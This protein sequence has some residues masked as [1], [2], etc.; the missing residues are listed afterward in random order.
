MHNDNRNH[1]WEDHC[2][3]R[4]EANDA[5]TWRFVIELAAIVSL[6]T[7]LLS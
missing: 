4:N 3:R 1:K 2:R 6:L 7:Y 5:A